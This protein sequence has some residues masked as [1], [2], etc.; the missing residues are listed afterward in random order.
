MSA[1]EEAL[2]TDDERSGWEF[3]LF[4][5][6]LEVGMA[7][8]GAARRDFNVGRV[9][10]STTSPSFASLQDALKFVGP[11]M[12]QLTTGMAKL[13]RMADRENIE[14]AFGA[15]G[16]AGDADAIRQYAAAVPRFY[17]YLLDWA[18]TLRGTTGPDQLA[19]LCE[20]VA[21][22]AA[23][24][25]NEVDD[26]VAG[27]TAAIREVVAAVRSGGQAKGNINLPLNLTLD[28]A[29]TAD[30]I[31]TIQRLT[32]AAVSEAQ[33]DAFRPRFCRSPEDF[34]E[35][36]ADWLT[37]WGYTNVRR[38]P[39]GPDGGADVLADEAVAQVKALM[40]PVGRPDIQRLRGVAHD[41][42]AALFFSLN[43]YTP[44]AVAFAE[45]SGVALF[46]FSGYDGIVESCNDSADAV[47]SRIPHR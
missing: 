1:S 33:P 45:E 2:S 37:A 41:G 6:E 14:R 27:S 13:A 46:R 36:A 8:L 5:D 7:Q 42:R 25:L 34:E 44:G 11:H 29:A 23:R 32:D 20:K 10:A 40:L 30:A 21:L 16:Q 26:F 35:A 47:L 3:L 4:A 19:P 43:A 9:P 22:L 12:E 31:A 39:T 15:P 28:D 17:A 18:A 24:P 38:T